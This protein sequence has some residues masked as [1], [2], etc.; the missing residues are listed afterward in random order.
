MVKMKLERKGKCYKYIL[1][2]LD[3]FS[4]FHQ[5]APLES[6]SA[7]E[8][9]EKL[10]QIYL[11]YGTP[12]Q[13]Q[14]D[15]GGEFKKDVKQFCKMVNMIKSRPYNPKAQSKVGHSHRVFKRITVI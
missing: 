10:E 14:S 4:R 15:N 2:L 6:K 11:I 8:V 3:I 1:S 7:F 9:N 13:L 12:K 5:L